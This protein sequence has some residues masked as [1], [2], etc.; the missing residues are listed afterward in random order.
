MASVARERD[1]LGIKATDCDG[2]FLGINYF[3]LGRNGKRA[4]KAQLVKA[5]DAAQWRQ[6]LQTM[7]LGGLGAELLT[8]FEGEIVHDIRLP[9]VEETLQCRYWGIDFVEVS[10]AAGDPRAM[11]LPQVLT[12]TIF[13]HPYLY[14]Y[15]QI[16]RLP[17]AIEAEEE[18]IKQAEE[19]AFALEEEQQRARARAEHA[20]EAAAQEARGKAEAE[21]QRREAAASRIGGAG[22]RASAMASARAALE[23][24][25]AARAE[26][27][28]AAK[29]K[30]EA[31]AAL[32]KYELVQMPTSTELKQA[33]KN[34]RGVDIYPN[35]ATPDYCIHK[36]SPDAPDVCLLCGYAIRPV[37]LG[38]LDELE[39]EEAE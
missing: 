27:E 24:R 6:H 33:A 36:P 32:P 18:A 25:R 28:A 39:G 35:A 10:G 11:L 2:V 5:M 19:E 12:G 15:A 20:E 26:A 1:A 38:N 23:K 29:A 37:A 9:G 3:E 7:E 34:H 31:E 21:R 8:T 17:E 22:R 4:H 30:A 14:V 13:T 16:S